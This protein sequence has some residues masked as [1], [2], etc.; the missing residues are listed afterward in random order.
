M[1]HSE[2]IDDQEEAEEAFA[3]RNLRAST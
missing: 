1:T 3:D 2:T